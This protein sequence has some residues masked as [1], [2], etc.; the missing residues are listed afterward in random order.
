M[1][2]IKDYYFMTKFNNLEMGDSI[3]R[4]L[5]VGRQGF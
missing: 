2:L 5:P 3:D 1:V 4:Y